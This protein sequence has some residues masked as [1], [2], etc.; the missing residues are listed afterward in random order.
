VFIFFRKRADGVLDWV[1]KR[2]CKVSMSFPVF[3]NIFR[4][5]FFCGYLL[6]ILQEQVFLNSHILLFFLYHINFV[7]LTP[8]RVPFFCIFFPA[9][10]IIFLPRYL[11]LFYFFL[12]TSLLTIFSNWVRG[13]AGDGTDPGGRP[14]KTAR[15]DPGAAGGGGDTSGPVG[16][17]TR[18]VVW[19]RNGI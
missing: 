19:A 13:P 18:A 9:S 17:D 15:L 7:F 4:L 11:C 10:T 1:R 8:Q 16:E 12:E 6:K 14:A 3:L 5:P 2:V